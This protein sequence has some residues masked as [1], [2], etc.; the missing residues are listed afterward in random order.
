VTGGPEAARDGAYIGLDLG[1]SGLKAVALAADGRV[2]ARGAAAYPTSTPEAGAREQDP[3]HWR[4]AVT[5]ALTQLGAAVP[6]GRWRGIGLSAMIP[7]LVT[8]DA[9]GEPA[10]PAITWQDSRADEDGEELRERFGP[11]RLYRLTGQWV[12]GR[13]L[14]PMFA[15]L[16]VAEP[17]RA[18][19]T[20]TIASAKD[21]LFGWLTGHLATDPST[22]SGYGCYELAAGRWH[23]AARDAALGG[24]DRPPALPPVLAS[25]A[26]RPLRAELAGALDCRSVPVCLG[27][28]DSVL[29]ALGLGV[30]EPGQAAYIAGTSNVIM[31]V[32]GELVLDPGHR[33]LV[34]PLA[35]PGRWGVEMDL[36]AT[37]SAIG[38]L[39]GLLGVAAGPAGITALAAG[40]D[41]RAAPVVLPY[42]SPGEQGALWDPRLHGAIAGLTLGHGREHL[43]RGLVNGIILESRRCLGVLAE[44][45]ALG[46]AIEVAGGSAADPSF[47]AD[48]ADA[49]RCRVSMPGDD[50]T[51]YSARGAALLAAS[52]VDGRWPPATETGTV[53]A[54]PDPARAELWDELWVRY[55]R[56]RRAV[57]GFDHGIALSG[58]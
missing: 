35:E 23:D 21:Y 42:L 29:G 31:G 58:V 24:L 40:T 43:A 45:G 37:G 52:A 32:T 3:A 13:Y 20:T 14:L 36:L 50:D 4:A 10:G 8:L 11:D 57:T 54:E 17:A 28:A 27:A 9:A 51:D 30:R 22:A 16:A 1:T 49:S 6:A 34:T 25:T 5:S 53:V 55:E 41:P 38:W 46:Q 18:R 19:A 56:A 39:S 7:T 26:I 44:I 12:D 33:F 15:R 2:L 48:L 47:R